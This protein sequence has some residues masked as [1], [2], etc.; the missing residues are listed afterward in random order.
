MKY[1]RKQK[2]K[3]IT[4][5]QIEQCLDFLARIM[6]RYEPDF[7]EC[8]VIFERLERELEIVRSREASMAHVR[9]RIKQSHG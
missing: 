8:I 4:I 5:K 7:D 9:A 2:T 1:E 3:P 6:V